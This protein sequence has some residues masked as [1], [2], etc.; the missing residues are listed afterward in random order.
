MIDFLCHEP[1]CSPVL[2]LAQ[3]LSCA[4]FAILFLQSGID[5]VID[6]RGNMDWLTAHFAGSLLGE[7]V[8]LMLTLVTLFELAAGALSAAGVVALLVT[9][10][11]DL[12]VAGVA[13]SALSLLML[14]FGQ[15]VARDYAGAAVIVSY[16]VLA[17][18]TLFLFQA[19]H[20]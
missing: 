20:G 17:M 12:A 11:G 15:R 10:S 19:D 4:F 14:F 3:V 2:R 9:G 7:Q 5:K 13:L 16:F 18:F 6:R 8:P 1:A